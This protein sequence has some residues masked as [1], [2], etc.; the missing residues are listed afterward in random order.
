MAWRAGVCRP[1]LMAQR[2]R[3]EVPGHGTIY[4]TGRRHA[5]NQVY[6]SRA[7]T[8][9]VYY[10]PYLPYQAVGRFHRYWCDAH[11]FQNTP[12]SGA[13]HART[14]RLR[15]VQQAQR[16]SVERERG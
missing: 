7:C 3:V 13:Q 8:H 1:G 10:L 4:R 2:V 15:P 5:Q 14:R 11:L 9:G 6:R 12:G 16:T